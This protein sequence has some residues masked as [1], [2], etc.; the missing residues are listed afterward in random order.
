[1][2]NRKQT[3]LRAFLPCYKVSLTLVLLAFLHALLPLYPA[4]AQNTPPQLQTD[5]N[6]L[7]LGNGSYVT[8][9]TDEKLNV[10]TLI[11]RHENNLRGAKQ[12]DN[13]IHTALSGNKI[14]ILITVQNTSAATDWILF[15]G[16]TFDG[17]RGM[18][19]N[20]TY[21]NHTTG[22]IIPSNNG[23]QKSRFLGSAL[24]ITLKPIAQNT[25]VLSLEAE[26]GL[27]VTLT[28]SIYS[29][30]AYMQKLRNG[31]SFD[32]L[33]NLFLI[34]MLAFFSACIYM[35]RD[36]RSLP[37]LGFYLCLSAYLLQSNS[38]FIAPFPLAG[39]INIFLLST[40]VGLCLLISK[41]FMDIRVN[42]HPL[43][44][45]VLIVLTA[46]LF[47][48]AVVYAFV[49]GQSLLGF[50]IFASSLICVLLVNIVMCSLIGRTAPQI[51]MPYALGW[52]FFTIGTAISLL[53]G[54][55]MISANWF[56]INAFWI[57]L[58]PQ[59]GCLIYACIQKVR[60]E[61]EIRK[62]EYVRRKQEEQNILRLQKSKESADQARLLRVIE[63]ERELMGELREREIRR[64]EEM[65]QAKD[66]ADRANQ[67]K[68]AFLAVVSHEIRTPM[69]GIMGMVRLLNDT[70]L[71][72][73][74]MDYVDTIN[75]SGETMMAL[76]NDILD[77]EKI[78]SGSMTLECV[79]FDLPQLAK[80][81]VTLMSGHAAQK[82]LN[83]KTDIS[84]NTP[85]MVLGDPTRL[86]QILLNLVN[87]GL[88]FT[89]NGG[90]SIEIS[91][92]SRE[93]NINTIKI[94]VCDTGIGIS[95]EAQKK[96]FT[97]FTQAE[98]STSRKYGGTGLGLAIS[99]RLIEA[100]DG[101]IHVESIEGQGSKFEFTL[102]LQEPSAAQ[103]SSGTTPQQNRQTT[104]PV[105]ILV[106]EDNEMNRKVLHGLL[107]RDGHTV[108]LA[109]NGLECLALCQ[110]E[111]P[112][113]ILM[114]I[115]MSGMDGLETT[116]KI[117]SN[118][119]DAISRIPIIALTGNVMLE[120]IEKYFAAQMNG[121]IAKPIDPDKLQ[122]TIYNASI[123][124]F[125]NPLA[126]IKEENPLEHVA[127][128]LSLDDREHF[129]AD[130]PKTPLDP[131]LMQ[132]TPFTLEDKGGIPHNRTPLEDHV[133]NNLT[134][135][136]QTVPSHAQKGRETIAQQKQD[137]VRDYTPNEK[138]ELTEI[139]RF[140]LQQHSS[141]QPHI[142][143]EPTAMTEEQNTPQTPTQDSQNTSEPI[144]EEMLLDLTALQSL[145]N[146]LGRDK[147]KDLLSGFIEKTNEIV[148]SMQQLAETKDI[149]GLS[150]RAHEL[151]GMAGN[152]GMKYI[153]D[154][155]GQ[156]EKAAKTGKWQEAIEY[157]IKLPDINRQTKTNLQ[158]WL[159]S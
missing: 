125:E 131:E 98:T 37:F 150:A 134:S 121:F 63:R 19:K 7:P 17:R 103:Q 118:Q 115:E 135:G 45:I 51:T 100:M 148:A 42:E 157:T 117:R 33:A 126:S 25:L 92:L 88:K 40:C 105:R 69:T 75:K 96:L 47:A 155:A 6:F 129:I 70:V 14:W 29:P 9:E 77:F 32:I 120:H 106:V 127:H 3:L 10:E 1:M 50:S 28:P 94:S 34:G 149:N 83:L 24:P 78:E 66:M 43:E 128:N 13:I 91:T 85:R 119:N 153:S 2:S 113:L 11:S 16:D 112:D 61:K 35:M 36:I 65:R 108:S 30:Y 52:T 26:S 48:G 123:G 84:A 58:P 142:A 132:K 53:A 44:N 68:S 38:A 104:K 15:L 101:K 107:S 74:Q 109:A 56:A 151:K 87:N 12:T 55:G 152:F 20:V 137:I 4:Q 114:D 80:D 116:H 146:T 136:L 82:N 5:T 64:T 130:K 67:A 60:S 99:N 76:L 89:H 140:L 93:N 71:S 144:P 46:A 95:P 141:S 49:T 41:Y 154:V 139:Q 158:Q 73:T 54:A 72:K 138:K 122:T 86:R 156:A 111:Q 110:N 124:K 27:P 8:L 81:V 145:S 133:Q 62:Q 57:F 143:T 23:E 159:K 18:V 90:V 31:N 79:P 97:P 102:R 147:L 22:D 39:T 21:Y 59:A